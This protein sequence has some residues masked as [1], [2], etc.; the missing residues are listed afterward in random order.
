MREA[1]IGCLDGLRGC[2][3]LWV[4]MGHAMLLTGFRVPVLGAAD[5]GVD[6]FIMLSGFLMV[7]HYED[8]RARE[9]WGETSTW[10]A[11]WTRRF[12]RISPLYY[13]ILAVALAIAPMLGDM[14]AEI[15]AAVA[16]SATDSVRYYDQSLS[17]A[18]MHVT[19]LFGLSPDYAFRTPL[20]D[21][22]IGLEMQYYAAFPLIMLLVARFGYLAVTAVA[23]A[24]CVLSI[25]VFHG[26]LSQF[27]MPALLVFKLPVFAA[28]ML[29][30]ADLRSGKP[31]NPV[32]LLLAASFTVLSDVGL[33]VD[34]RTIYR[35][36]LFFGFAVLLEAHLLP[37]A[38]RPVVAL[39]TLLGTPFFR[40]LGDASYCVYLV[41][42]LVMIPVTAWAIDTFGAGQPLPLRFAMVLPVTLALVLPIAWLCKITIEDT[43]IRMGRAIISRAR[44]TPQAPQPTTE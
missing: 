5:L 15:G 33:G 4:L 40:F 32:C 43:G 21:W 16:N 38:R 3:A 2:A 39:R 23:T 14:R 1:H 11:F 35:L 41:H 13:V 18:L 42:L 30:A 24:L 19:Y 8:R 27:P 44:R 20:P 37:V 9:P 26:F 36:V 6:L 22:S 7:H 28:G 29:V 10:A 25:F 31:G 17:N 12:F 34:V